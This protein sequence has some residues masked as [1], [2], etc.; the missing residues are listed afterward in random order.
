MTLQAV[1]LLFASAGCYDF[2]IGLVSYYWVT[3][4]CPLLFKPFAVIDGVMFILFLL[5]YR[6]RPAPR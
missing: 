2:I 5:A 1:R 6:S 3:T 4:D